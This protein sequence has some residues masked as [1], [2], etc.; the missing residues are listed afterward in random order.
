M[1]VDDQSHRVRCGPE[2]HSTGRCSGDQC[3][4]DPY[5]GDPKSVDQTTCQISLRVNSA[6]RNNCEERTDDPNADDQT[7]GGR[8]AADQK[9]ADRNNCGHPKDD[10]R[11]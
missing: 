4:D 1:S 6:D 7:M 2:E 11:E 3:V 5:V 10:H 8:N 9:T